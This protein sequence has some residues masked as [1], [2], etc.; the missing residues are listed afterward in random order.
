MAPVGYI[1]LASQACR[2]RHDDSSG[3]TSPGSASAAEM[4]QAQ[5]V[6]IHKVNLAWLLSSSMLVNRLAA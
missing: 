2:R 3:P 4:M 6:I 5:L 1:I